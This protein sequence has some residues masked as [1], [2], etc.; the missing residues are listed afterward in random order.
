[1]RKPL[2]IRLFK[3]DKDDEVKVVHHKRSIK[4]IIKV[5]GTH[6]TVLDFA[7]ALTAAI[8][9][10]VKAG[11]TDFSVAASPDNTSI[12]LTSTVVTPPVKTETFVA[13]PSAQI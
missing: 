1:M 5:K 4:R 6:M 12:I 7:A 2:K 11:N 8:Q 9:A 13:N 10:D 3:K